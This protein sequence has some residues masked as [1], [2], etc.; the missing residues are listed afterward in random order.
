MNKKPVILL[1]YGNNTYTAIRI[2]REATD[3]DYL[4]ARKLLGTCPIELYLTEQ[5]I[6]E[7]EST[8]AKIVNKSANSVP[9]DTEQDITKS[10]EESVPKD[11]SSINNESND[12]DI[13]DNGPVESSYPIEVHPIMLQNYISEKC[14][15]I[16]EIL[17]YSKELVEAKRSELSGEVGWILC[18]KR[19]IYY[20]PDDNT[21]YE[22]EYVL[23]LDTK[24]KWKKFHSESLY[25]NEPYYLE[26]TYDENDFDDFLIEFDFSGFF[27]YGRNRGN[28]I[29]FL[30]HEYSSVANTQYESNF[31]YSLTRVYDKGKGLLQRLIEIKDSCEQAK[32]ITRPKPVSD[33]MQNYHNDSKN[34]QWKGQG[35]CQYCGGIFKGL[36]TK[37]CSNC[38]RVKDY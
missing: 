13:D 29:A 22:H 18:K 31:H 20:D 26:C 8:G 12:F 37:K 10:I 4:D 30:K 23:V 24:G 36:F 35:R 9:F 14:D 25:T 32:S 33:T 38:G 15:C 19:H 6:I 27:N 28:M 7:L 34:N 5:Q 17:K 1:Y 3:L 16:D 21:N 11:N 2:V